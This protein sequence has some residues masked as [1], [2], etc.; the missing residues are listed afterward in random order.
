MPC[1]RDFGLIKRQLNK[2]ERFY[3]IEE[4]SGI[5]SKASKNKQKFS[6]VR[7]S[8]DL[9]FDYKNWWLGF[10]KKTCL[11]NESYG[12]NV[13]RLQKKS[14]A[15]ASFHHF[16]ISSGNEIV[17]REF[18]NCP[19]V[20]TYRLRNTEKQITYCTKRAYPDKLPI[21][22]K[23]MTD[24]LNT[25]KFIPEEYLDFWREITMWPTDEKEGDIE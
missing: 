2:T 11:S 6:V 16:T 10:Y 1:D 13:P 9:V 5:I 18:I 3:T 7:V 19:V 15:I 23:K 8:T 24:I 25:I 21:N 22:K 12:K 20:D 4:Y 17:C 14:F